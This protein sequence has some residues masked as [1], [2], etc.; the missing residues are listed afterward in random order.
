[1]LRDL[2]DRPSPWLDARMALLGVVIL[3]GCNM[4]GWFVPM[5]FGGRLESQ[6]DREYE[7][8]ALHAQALGFEALR[9]ELKAF[10][11][12][13]RGHERYFLDKVAGHPALPFCPRLFEWGPPEAGVR[14]AGDPAPS[15]R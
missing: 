5:D 10:A 6:N 13:E 4:V 14:R 9:S 15:G 7:E 11:Q 12:L 8:A 1:M 3:I 2:S